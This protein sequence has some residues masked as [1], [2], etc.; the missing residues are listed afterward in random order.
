MPKEATQKTVTQPRSKNGRPTM[1]SRRASND[2]PQAGAESDERR[3][4]PGVRNPIGDF[5]EQT[6][7]NFG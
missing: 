5:S 6:G 7:A 4:C 1:D 3:R 2:R